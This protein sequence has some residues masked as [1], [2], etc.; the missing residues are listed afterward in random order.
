MTNAKP[1]N[2]QLPMTREKFLDGSFTARELFDQY[3]QII[4]RPPPITAT[5]IAGFGAGAPP[6][7][8]IAASGVAAWHMSTTDAL[9]EQIKI[10][11]SAWLSGAILVRLLCSND[12]AA[13]TGDYTFAPLYNAHTIGDTLIAPA[14]AFDVSPA[15][16]VDLAPDKTLHT[17][18]AQIAAETA[19]IEAL[20]PGTD[21]LTLMF[22]A[23]L[24]GISTVD[25]LE[26]E[27][28]V[29]RLMA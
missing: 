14:T 29:P 16:Q 12:E 26:I 20:V 1:A 22:T 7:T 19:A 27:I 3:E 10:P 13:G 6:I 23:T 5:G 25:V 11:R 21:L 17:A 9:I 4:R 18:W 2:H 8:E 15:T 24:N 28:L